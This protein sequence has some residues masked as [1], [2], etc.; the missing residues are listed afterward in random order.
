MKK[1][2]L[3]I[4][5]QSAPQGGSHHGLRHPTRPVVIKKMHG[6]VIARLGEE[7][8]CADDISIEKELIA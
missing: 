7:Q 4:R 2:A 5:G 3:V 6:K 8:G 1:T